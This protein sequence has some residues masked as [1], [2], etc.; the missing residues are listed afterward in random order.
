MV[1]GSGPKL[2]IADRQVSADDP[3]FI[4][5]E[6]SGNHLGKIDRALRTIEAAAEAGA[7]A[8]KL[9][10]YTADTITIDCDSELFRISGGLWDGSTLYELYGRAHTPYEWHE[11]LFAKARECGLIALSTPFDQ[12]A[13]NLLAEL[14]SPAYKIA[15]FEVVDLPLIGAVARQGKPLLISTGMANLGEIQDAVATARANG[16]SDIALLHCTSAYPA[17]FG[18][19][20]VRTMPHLAAAFD[21]LPGLSDHTPGTAASVAAVALGATII[22]KHFTLSRADG[23]PDAAF[24]LEPDEFKRLVADCRAAWEALGRIEY[25]VLGCEQGNAIFRRSLFVVEPID[26]GEEFT[27]RNVRSIR[28]GYGLPPKHLP[29]IL[30]RRAVRALSRGEPLSWDAVAP[31]AAAVLP[32]V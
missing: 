18:E 30:G 20:N 25:E 4:I 1:S 21:A 13:I 16:A 11:R 10:T 9:Q 26:E 12:T 14:K 22:E 8:I 27:P 28:P 5:A 7:D 2:K 24:S 32:D 17:S 3:P 31:S 19:A 15:S 23:G 29:A 6:L